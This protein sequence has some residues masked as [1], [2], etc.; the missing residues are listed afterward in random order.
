WGHG[1]QE[2]FSVDEAIALFD[3]DGVGKSPSRFDMKKLLSMNGIYIRAADDLRLAGIAAQRI[4]PQAEIDLLTQ[5]MPA[6]KLRAR[7]MNELADGAMF[8]FKA[9]PL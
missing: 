5:A 2:E 8:L 3:L 7:D 6:L 4:G 1:D 9:R